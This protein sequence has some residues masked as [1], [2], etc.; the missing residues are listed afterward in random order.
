MA[1]SQ[2]F[3]VLTAFKFHIGGAMASSTTL[4][5]RLTDLT[6]KAK[7]LNEQLKFSAFHW[8]TQ[9]TGTQF[10]VI[11]F[12]KNV[13]DMSNESYEAQ[14]K[15]ATL[16]VNNQ[17]NFKDGPKTMA[18]AMKI[19]AFHMKEISKDADKL[20]V[21]SWEYLYKVQELNAMLVKK[22]ATGIDFA[23]SR[24][25]AGNF[26]LGSDMLPGL[27]NVDMTA[28]LSNLVMGFAS[29][30]QKLF[31]VLRADTDTFKGVSD[32]R[33]NALSTK[34]RVQMLNKAMEELINDETLKYRAKGLGVSL[35]ILSNQFKGV[36]SVF[37][38]LGDTIR[39]SAVEQIQ[40]LIKYV[41]TLRPFFDKLGESLRKLVEGK[42]LVDLYFELRKIASIG[43]SLH[44][45]KT[46]SYFTFGLQELIGV[47]SLIPGFWRTTGAFAIKGFD[48]LFKVMGFVGVSVAQLVSKFRLIPFLFRAIFSYFKYFGVFFVLSRALEKAKIMG[49]ERTLKALGNNI[50]K[51]G[52]GV[53]DLGEIVIKLKA[54]FTFLTDAMAKWIAPLFSLVWW[55]EKFGNIIAFFTGQKIKTATDSI[56]LF[57]D[58]LLDLSYIFKSITAV[59]LTFIAK[60]QPYLSFFAKAGGGANPFANLGMWD[61]SKVLGG[62]LSANQIDPKA[63]FYDVY[64]SIM[65]TINQAGRKKEDEKG[66]IAK[67]ITNIGKVEIRNQFAENFDPDRVAV[68]IIEGL[69][70][71]SNNK[72][73]S[74]NNN[75]LKTVG[76]TQRIR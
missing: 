12:F 33:F 61:S 49:Q 24:K 75:P 27:A 20:G 55:A 57:K 46:L 7:G 43:K 69:N 70:K 6:D 60:A 5:K 44:Q 65:D 58:A 56:N 3:N 54:P 23:D 64:S 42:S 2:T 37:K 30:Q 19:S 39:I 36:D 4:G 25:L 18:E 11:G 31:R 35:T 68:T 48:K 8:G 62:F 26:M 15:M 10:G 74:L 72:L 32:T 22:N 47:L 76:L 16:L 14:R 45:A 50:G 67:S 28:S 17:K 52:E 13:L 40:S 29:Q 41:K 71:A 53:L 1:V 73:G 21:D 59:V 63:S 9:L 66:E 51:I 34:K 38:K